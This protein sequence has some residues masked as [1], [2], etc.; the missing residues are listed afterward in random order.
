MK[1]RTNKRRG[2]DEW[3]ENFDR[4]NTQNSCQKHAPWKQPNSYGEYPGDICC[5]RSTSGKCYEHDP[6]NYKIVRHY[7]AKARKGRK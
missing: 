6:A 3:E 5:K 2:K 7:T 4:K 1:T